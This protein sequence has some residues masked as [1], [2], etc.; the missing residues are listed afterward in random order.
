MSTTVNGTTE[1]SGTGPASGYN[2]VLSHLFII[3]FLFLY[4]L[5]ANTRNPYTVIML[6]IFTH[7]MICF[8]IFGIKICHKIPKNLT[9]SCTEILTLRKFHVAA[10]KEKFVPFRK[11]FKKLAARCTC[12]LQW[13]K[14]SAHLL[15]QMGW[16]IVKL[17]EQCNDQSR[18]FLRYGVIK[19]SDGNHMAL[20]SLDVE[21]LSQ[22]CVSRAYGVV[23]IS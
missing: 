7:S 22:V 10:R 16:V 23:H 2:L 3:L 4:R 11:R 14:E 20:Q 1:A 5:S 6:L 17:P 12:M 8:M 15:T 19:Y 18:A 9:I 13:T 21:L